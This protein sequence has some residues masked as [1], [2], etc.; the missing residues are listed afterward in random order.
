MGCGRGNYAT[1]C[2]ACNLRGVVLMARLVYFHVDTA[3][4]SWAAAQ[5]AAQTLHSAKWT[6]ASLSV[7][8]NDAATQALVKIDGF[9]DSTTGVWNSPMVLTE[10]AQANHATIFTDLAV[11]W[12]GITP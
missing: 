2:Q 10:Y 8:P 3:H 12:S 9:P 11:G 5:T 4:G 1:T 7:T 6:G